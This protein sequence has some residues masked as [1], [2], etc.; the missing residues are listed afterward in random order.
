MLKP[1]PSPALSTGAV[2]LPWTAPPD[3]RDRSAQVPR[4]PPSGLHPTED[5]LPGSRQAGSQLAPRV[6]ASLT[7][8]STEALGRGQPCSC[9]A[10]WAGVRRARGG[11]VADTKPQGTGHIPG[12][13]ETL[14]QH[15]VSARFSSQE[16]EQEDGHDVPSMSLLG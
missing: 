8:G 6:L 16:W 1:I 7:F 15:L 5:S 3:P 9:P 12:G 2:L 10:C 4:R 11:R 14:S 13:V